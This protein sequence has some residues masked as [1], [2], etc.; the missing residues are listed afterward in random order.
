M[1]IS[2]YDP[3]AMVKH[4]AECREKG[5]RFVADPSQQVTRMDGEQLHDLI[6][7]ADLLFTNAYERELLESKTGLSD[8]RHRGP[9]QRPGDDAGLARGVEIVGGLRTMHMPV[10]K[11]RAKVDPTGVGDAFRGGFLTARDWGLSWERAAEVGGLLA[12]MVLESVG[13]Q[14]Y[15][16]DEGRVQR[17]AWPSPT[18]TTAPPRSCRT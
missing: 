8:R 6:Q 10:A 5:L 15:V 16:V 17:P 4:S 13:T 2:A 12:A 3:A 1:V 14:E 18:A 7:G 11:E 9:G